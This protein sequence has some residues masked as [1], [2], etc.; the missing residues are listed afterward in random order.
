MIDHRYPNKRIDIDRDDSHCKLHA[1][2]LK[3]QS[4][5]SLPAGYLGNPSRNA[6]YASL[7]MPSAVTMPLQESDAIDTRDVQ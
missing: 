3:V 1:S 7:G 5:D 6:V 2:H 4:K